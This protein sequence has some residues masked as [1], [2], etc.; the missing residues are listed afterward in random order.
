[1]SFLPEHDR[2]FLE[3]KEIHFEEVKEGDARG[4]VLRG[5]PI[6]AGLFKKEHDQLVPCDCAD[7]LVQVPTGYNDAKLDSFYVAPPLYL[8]TGNA[9][10]N[11]SITT[12]FGEE[13][14]FWSR[15]QDGWRA[16]IDGLDTYLP[17]IREALAAK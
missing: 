13:C 15:H 2:A 12:L 10:Q 17:L 8:S 9:P 16:G 5:V 14:Q 11:T 7:V 4:V 3:R 6:P 1:M